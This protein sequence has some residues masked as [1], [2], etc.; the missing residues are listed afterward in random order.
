MELVKNYEKNLKK[1]NDNRVEWEKIF[2]Q[3]YKNKNGFT[4]DELEIL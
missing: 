1:L 3:K 2:N 4:E